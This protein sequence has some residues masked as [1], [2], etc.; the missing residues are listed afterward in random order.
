MSKLPS[1]AQVIGKPLSE[2]LDRMYPDQGERAMAEV[3]AQNS[4][5]VTS[6][7]AEIDAAF[8]AGFNDD[9]LH[10]I[11]A[12]AVERS[13]ESGAHVVARVARA[14]D[15]GEKRV[16]DIHAGVSRAIARVALRIKTDPANFILPE[17]PQ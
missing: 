12:G 10:Q 3:L 17:R 15:I 14:L 4:M 11:K 1:A 13:V 16:L 8:A 2:E 5:S 7:L 6:R 9:T